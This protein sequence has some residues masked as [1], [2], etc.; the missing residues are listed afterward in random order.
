MP[1]REDTQPAFALTRRWSHGFAWVL[2]AATL[3]LLAAGAL[4]TGTGS[5][6]A[7]PDWPLAYGELFPPLVGGI[8]YEHG[9]RLVATTVGLLTILL[10]LWL[11]WVEPRRWVKGL[12]WGALALVIVQGLLGGITVLWLLPKP[13]SIGHAVFAQLFF[14]TTVLLMQVT[15]PG[16]D[17]LIETAQAPRSG[18]WGIVTTLAL[19]V[20]LLLGATVR[21]NGAGLAIPDFPL[22]FGALVPPLGSFPIAIHFLHRVGAVVVALLAGVTVWTA[23][24]EDATGFLR[25]PAAAMG[26]L[27]AVQIL[28][29]GTVIWSE[30][31]VPITTLHL[32]VG[33]LLL[34][35]S[36]LLTLRALAR[37][38]GGAA[39]QGATR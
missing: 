14:L 17:R 39:L 6:L 16:W 34:A 9:H 12:A 29:G 23:I 35:A 5:S 18:R 11:W 8:L 4:V 25:L 15:A 19:L 37:S 32:V 7:V 36:A 21:H 30:K 38:G 13:I 33:A 10:A 26:L 1:T 24:R 27:V 3:A 31:A 2:C 28:L 20:Q 22:A